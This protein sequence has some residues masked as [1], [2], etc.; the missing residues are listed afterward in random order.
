MDIK[1]KLYPYPVLAEGADDF[2][3]SS[4][5]FETA[6]SRGIREIKF[7]FTMKLKNEEILASLSRVMQNI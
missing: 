1:Y 3:S 5:T 6:V 2:V 7:S 4:F